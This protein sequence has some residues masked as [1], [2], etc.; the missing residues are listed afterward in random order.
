VIAGGHAIR[1]SNELRV[2]GPDRFRTVA[3]GFPDLSF[4][5]QTESMKVSSDARL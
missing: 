3:S 2:E 5:L 1:V 4:V